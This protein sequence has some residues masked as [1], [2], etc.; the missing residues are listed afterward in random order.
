MTE[1]LDDSVVDRL[2]ELPDTLDEPEN[3]VTT[4]EDTV[5]EFAPT[6]TV[7]LEDVSKPD[8]ELGNAVT[9]LERDDRTLFAPTRCRSDTVMESVRRGLLSETH[10]VGKNAV[11]AFAPQ[12][13]EPVETGQLK[14]LEFT[15]SCFDVCRI[16]CDLLEGGR[17]P[18]F[19]VPCQARW[20]L[21]LPGSDQGP[22]VVTSRSC[23]T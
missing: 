18:P 4:P 3:V 8:T 11:V 7:V 19:H 9:W 6:T 22:G 23:S 15:A 21:A 2:N 12:V 1:S 10:V 13:C 20:C 16:L 5:V 17:I 14:V